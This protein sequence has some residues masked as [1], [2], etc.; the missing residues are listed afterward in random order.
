MMYVGWAADPEVSTGWGEAPGISEGYVLCFIYLCVMIC[1][2]TQSII[3]MLL[4]F[5]EVI[6]LIVGVNNNNNHNNS[7]D[8]NDSNNASNNNG[9]VSFL[10]YCVL[11]VFFMFDRLHRKPRI[12]GGH[13]LGPSTQLQVRL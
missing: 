13:H 9:I 4:I 11:Y 1:E 8:H 12:P 5:I 7:T 3:V 6:L 10:A 2:I